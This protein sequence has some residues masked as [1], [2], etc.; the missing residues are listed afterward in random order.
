LDDDQINAVVAYIRSWESNP[1]V[2]LPPEVSA[3]ALSLSGAEI[4]ADICAQCHG[5][6]GEGGV[7]PAFADPKFQANNSDED[8]F[9]SISK[10]HPGTSMIAW[11]GIL[12]NE[13][14]QALINFIRQLKVEETVEEP[15]EEPAPVSQV[16]TFE[17][18]VSPIF[19]AKCVVC[20][21]KLGG[22][23][24]STFENA[25]TTGNN[26]P[27]VIPGDVAASLLAQKLLGTH[28]EGTI[29]PPNGKL[30]DEE[31]QVIL[32]WITSGAL[33]K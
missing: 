15:V 9:G 20:H 18:D 25:M 2:E 4:Y 5:N 6:N 3:E 26:A 14:F 22:W 32:D 10:G 27:V 8:I 23:D 19:K 24:G 21:G 7:G 1:P 28:Q 33:E 17:S 12:T 13:Q 11:S 30:P 29:M 16:V 31:I